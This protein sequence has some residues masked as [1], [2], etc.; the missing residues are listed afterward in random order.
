MPHKAPGKLPR[1]GISF[2][3]LIRIFVAFQQVRV[4]QDP[5]G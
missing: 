2:A 4:V 5:D 3:K 1:K